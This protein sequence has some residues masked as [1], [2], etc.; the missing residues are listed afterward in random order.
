[1]NKKQLLLNGLL[2]EN[3]TLVLVLGTCPTL[4]LTTLA[5]NAV[6]MGLA[7]TFV[8][9]GSNLF[10]S[11]FKNIIPDKVR[12]P[13]YIVIIAGFV[14]VVEMLIKAFSPALEAALGIYIPLI[15]V[16]CII[17]GRAEMFANK[18]SVADS[19]LDGVSMGIG[20]MLAL[21]VMGTIREILG[22]GSWM[23]IN[24]T[25]DLFAP[26]H[27]FSTPPGGFLTFGAIIAAVVFVTRKPVQNACAACPAAESC[28]HAA[29]ERE[30]R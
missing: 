24:L 20:F 2:K 4:A 29:C 10:I 19:V 30:G 21:L 16:N 22:K 8:L 11:L 25:A 15:V 26:I 28:G 7:T 6:G 5:S 14:S 23:G 12:I 27:F 9:V 13:C 1:M 17:L 3:P 18:N